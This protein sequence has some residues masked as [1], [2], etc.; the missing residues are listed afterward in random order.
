MIVININYWF[1]L[2]FNKVLAKIMRLFKM[3]TNIKTIFRIFKYSKCFNLDYLFGI[4]MAKSIVFIFIFLSLLIS[5]SSLNSQV[6]I[7]DSESFAIHPKAGLMSNHYT[8]DFKSFQGSVDCG[9]FTHGKGLGW[10]G[11]IFVEKDFNSTYQIGLGAFYANRSGVLALLNS[12]QTRDQ[13]TGR[14]TFVTL[15]NKMDAKISYLEISPEIRLILIDNLINGPFRFLTGFRVGI[16]I[17]H[18]FTQTESVVS[19]ANATFVNA[20]GQRT[21]V[22]PMASGSIQEMATQFGISTGFENLLNIGNGNYLTQQLVFDYNFNNIVSNT[23]WKALAVRFELG[24][25]FS[26]RKSE[27]EVIKEPEPE[28]VPEPVHEVIVIKEAPKPL[29]YLKFESSAASDFKLETGNELLATLPLVNSIFFEKNSSIIPKYYNLVK[30]ANI[31]MYKGDPV[32]YHKDILPVIVRIIEDN[33]NSRI[34]LEGTT[35]GQQNEPKGL[36]LAKSRSESVKQALVDLGL[37]ASI[38]SFRAIATPRYPSNQQYPEG[39]EDNQRVDILV[40]NAPLQKYVNL[41]NYAE[42]IGNVDLNIDYGNYPDQTK[43]MVSVNSER[44]IYDK[45]GKYKVPLRQRLRDNATD[46]KIVSNINVAGEVLTEEQEIKLNEIPNQIVDMRVNNFEALLRFNYNSSDLTDENQIL[47][48]QLIK[49]LPDGS[50]ILIIGSADML[51][52]DERNNQLASDR[53]RKTE[54]FIKQNAGSRI[55]IQTTTNL[56]KVSDSTPQGRFLNRSI[57]I[58]VK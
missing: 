27:P 46:F 38:I 21:T 57:K 34:M 13:N 25:R 50:T 48:K 26:V 3:M 28:V 10:T 6:N 31:N 43:A 53:A 40:T 52:T 4:I 17:Q 54:I 12:Y 23:D 44:M 19:P 55:F 29:P 58:R 11:G 51:G 36:E 39:I 5:S 16:P 30:P 14:T 32:A 35:S 41:Q 8:S 2:D 37:P 45:P 49:I 15:E 24:L 42:I 18:E 22:R 33:P 1:C 7:F 20:N 9:V 56:D 47:L